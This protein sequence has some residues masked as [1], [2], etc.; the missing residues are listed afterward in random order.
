MTNVVSK[1]R[2]KFAF[3]PEML[4]AR[5]QAERAKRIRPEGAGQYQ[6]TEGTWAEYSHDPHADPE[7]TRASIETDCDALVIGGGL[8]GLMMAGWLKEN[9]IDDVRV[10][11][12]GADFGGTWYWNRYPGARCDVESYIYMPFI[13]Q[14]NRMPS[15]K[16][17]RGREIFAHCQNVAA[18]YGLYEKA[19]LQTRLTSATWDDVAGRWIIK[20][21]RN[22]TV[23]ARFVC[24][25][26][27]V[28]SRPKLPGIP[29]IEKFKGHSF[30]TSRWDYAYTGGD[31][32]GDLHGLADKRVAVIGT[33]ASGIQVI[34]YVGEYAKQLYVFQ[35]TPSSIDVRNN[36]PTD[37]EWVK[38]LQPG[39]QKHRIANFDAIMLGLTEEEDLVNDRWTDVWR[40]LQV[41]QTND[42][43]PDNPVD[44][45]E[46][47]QMADY[48][49]MEELRARVDEIV[50]DSE[51][52]E[53][54]KPW[55]NIFC[56]RP[57]YS[58]EYLQTYNRPNVKL[59]DTQGRGPDEINETGLIFDGVQYDV[60]CIIY[61]SGFEFS[62]PTYDA[63]GYELIGRNGADPRN[64]LGKQVRTLHGIYTR[65][66]PNFFVIG[67]MKQ[68]AITVNFPH[69]LGE[70]AEHVARVIKLCKD[71]DIAV[72]EVSDAAEDRWDE[73]VRSKAIDRKQFERECTPSYL[74]RE[75]RPDEERTFFDGIYG[76]GPF[77]YIAVC[78][79]WRDSGFMQDMEIRRISDVESTNRGENV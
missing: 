20:T 77:E 76:G 47:L 69:V 65:G 79:E 25:G 64:K 37:P 71:N 13:E 21:D 60:D 66:F 44:P 15:E 7:F 29:G 27:G 8:T 18:H 62:Q 61:A 68:A 57:G 52:A 56:K 67:S 28:L 55:Y 2:E 45:A 31:E 41:W 1:V 36:R 58:D 46:L 32:T 34:P 51:T 22:D 24:A 14:I 49:K 48:S 16:Y 19:L 39:W 11:E 17:S 35:R 5:Y 78:K 30:H 73:I 70:Q 72:M 6:Q 74:N 54:L 10:I 4:R 50:Q 63:G 38:S 75:G 43:D 3:D 40:R 53:A 9:G 12:Q 23:R 59:V 26:T 33:G 42:A